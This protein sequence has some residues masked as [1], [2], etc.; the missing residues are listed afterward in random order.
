MLPYDSFLIDGPWLVSIGWILGKL[1]NKFAKSPE[2]AT[3][4]KWG[5][6]IATILI[7]YITSIG[8]YFNMEYTRWVWEL[9]GAE[10]GRD[11]MINSGV[12]NFDHE[13][14]SGKGHLLAAILFSSYPV[15]LAFGFKLADRKKGEC[16]CGD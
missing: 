5:L 4:A 3:K 11:W 15:W 16:T 14:V 12:F 1:I 7:F 2:D 6:G 13:N 9:C 10:S 8:L